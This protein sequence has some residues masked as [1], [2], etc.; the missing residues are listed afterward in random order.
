[1]TTAMAGATK[2]MQTANATG[3]LTGTMAEFARQSEMMNMTEEYG[4]FTTCKLSQNFDSFLSVCL[5]VIRM[6]DDLLDDSDEED[7]AQEIVDSVFDEIGLEV[8]SKVRSGVRESI[9]WLT[10]GLV[11]TVGRCASRSHQITS[12]KG[13]RANRCRRSRGR[14]LTE[15]T[16]LAFNVN[17]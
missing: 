4:C 5:L 10:I 16:S 1:M 11:S 15:A 12:T 13:T 2:A 7:E 9:R 6:L 3:N 8:D 14:R 17:T